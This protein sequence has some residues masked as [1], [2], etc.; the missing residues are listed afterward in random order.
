MTKV[1]YVCFFVFLIGLFCVGV[2]MLC[3]HRR[4]AVCNEQIKQK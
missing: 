3:S 2:W 1:K 4:S